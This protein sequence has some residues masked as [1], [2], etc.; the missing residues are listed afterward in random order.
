MLTD[1]RSKLILTVVFII[2]TVASPAAAQWVNNGV[3]AS[4]SALQMVQPVIA[5]DGFGGA[6]TAWA[7]SSE[8]VDPLGEIYVQ[9]YASNGSILWGANGVLVSPPSVDSGHYNIVPDGEGGAV[10][11]WGEP[12]GG[13]IQR[14]NFLGTKTWGPAGVD[15]A[16][17]VVMQRSVAGPS[18]A[19][20]GDDL[21]DLLPLGGG[22]LVAFA[23][24]GTASFDIF[25]QKV[26]PSGAIQ[27]GANGVTLCSATGAQTRPAI[28]SDGEG[29]AIVAWSDDRSGDMNIYAQRINFL[30][31]PMWTA[32]GVAVCTAAGV[33]SQLR[34][35]A[36][37]ASGVIIGWVDNRIPSQDIYA[38]RLNAGGV[39][40]WTADGE[41]VSVVPS[42]NQTT[43]SMASDDRGGAYLVWTDTRTMVLDGIEIFGQRLDEN[44]AGLWTQDGIRMTDAPHGMTTNRTTSAARDGS[45]G[46]IAAYAMYESGKLG[47]RVFRADSTGTVLWDQTAAATT[48]LGSK[49]VLAES[50][51]GGAIVAWQDQR[52]LSHRQVF[53]QKLPLVVLA[54][55]V[56]TPAPPAIELSVR[57]NPF[58]ASTEIRF[59][60]PSPSDAS[61][62]IYDVHGRRITTRRYVEST[63]GSGL[64]L[65]T[66]RDDAGNPL[67]SG[68]YFVR[69]SASGTHA[70]RKFV[71]IR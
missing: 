26:D 46:V 40:Q 48:T 29:G 61:L 68:V 50:D 66:G 6:V 70:T 38:Q 19:A 4:G 58:S 23:T 3:L 37:G 24:V 64:M 21:I 27:W 16:P 54:I 33:Q 32:N 7:E 41:P 43:L 25:V 62:Q 11:A 52:I 2:A 9:R 59:S 63:S 69:V 53:A 71:L 60:L 42:T 39:A 10:V 28:V 56:R 8:G 15:F 65:F 36:D 35:I 34:M 49:P 55:P 31:S 18:P 5:A 12:T 20:A 47:V 1:C 13:R 17:G 44:G 30:G 45:G 14:V 22:A 67:P 51:N 57:P